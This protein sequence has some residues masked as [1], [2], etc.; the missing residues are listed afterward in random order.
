MQDFL[1]VC[2]YVDDLIYTDTNVA[3]LDNFKNAM[4]KEYEMMDLGFMRYF[5]GIQSSKK[6]R[7]IA[8]SSAEAEYIAATDAACEAVWLRRIRSDMEHKEE[9]PTVIYCDNMSAIAMSKNPVFHGRTK[10]IEL[11]H[12]FIRDLVQNGEIQ[13]EF[14]NT[15]EQLA[16][17]MTKSVASEKFTQFHE[18]MKIT[19]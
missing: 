8:L 10:Q 11:R 9:G 18:V 12:H 19:N 13:L 4:M 1:I 15:K 2:L 3:M 17:I 16:D 7:T 6:Q 14:V 5:L